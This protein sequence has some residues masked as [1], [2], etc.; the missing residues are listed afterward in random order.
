MLQLQ[1]FIPLG[2]SLT[3]KKTSLLRSLYIL[4]PLIKVLIKSYDFN[5]ETFPTTDQHNE[6]NALHAYFLPAVSTKSATFP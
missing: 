6:N 5:M 2:N 4:S 1:L 3:F